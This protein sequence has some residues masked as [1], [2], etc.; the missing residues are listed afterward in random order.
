MG[1]EAQNP[2]KR[3]FSV[4]VVDDSPVMRMFIRRLLDVSGL[5]IGAVYD[6]DDGQSALE[7]LDRMP[8]DLVLSDINM[9]GMNGCE[10]MQRIAASP[11]LRRI[12]VIVISTD[13]S[14]LRVRYMIGLG[15][16]GY[17]QKPFHPETLRSEIERVLEL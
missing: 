12:P 10:L 9:P 5:P 15:A 17:I 4:L 11:T 13:S 7:R 2:R 16:R 8:I 3:E 14:H 6:S 1:D